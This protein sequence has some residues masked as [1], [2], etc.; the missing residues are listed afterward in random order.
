M[1]NALNYYL[2]EGKQEESK[3]KY[4]YGK[5]KVKQP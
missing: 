5:T 2:H 4:R 1:N 3:G